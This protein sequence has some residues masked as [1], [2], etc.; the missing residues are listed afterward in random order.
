MVAMVKNGQSASKPLSLNRYEEGSTTIP[1]GSTG[2]KILL[3]TP[4]SIVYKFIPQL[5]PDESGVYCIISPT[6]KIYI[7]SSMNFKKRAVRHLSYLR[8]NVHHSIKLQ[9]AFNKYTIDNFLFVVLKKTTDIINVEQQFLDKYQ[10][11]INGYNLLKTAKTYKPFN[12]SK[13]SIE[14]AIKSRMKKVVRIS[15]DGEEIT[16]FPSVCEA[17]KSVGTQSTNISKVCDGK[18]SSMCGYQFI[19]FSDYDSSK[20]YIWKKPT[21]TLSKK[22]R[23]NI[24]NV[25]KGRKKSEEYILAKSLK[26]GVSVSKLNDNGD[27]LITYISV[28]DAARKEN[29]SVQNLRSALK[30]GH[31]CNGMIFKRTKDIV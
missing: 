16:I 26:Y 18:F 15:C 4:D 10:P 23:E 30:R 31:K 3:E 11:Y 24:K 1:R 8:R 14:K 22:Q 17:A 19:Y 29:L 7:G 13:D 27:V 5:L 25:L 9:N 2:E 6:G 28:K 20:K 12:L 21:W